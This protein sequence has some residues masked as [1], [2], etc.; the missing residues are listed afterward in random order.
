MEY[1]NEEQIKEAFVKYLEQYQYCDAAD[2]SF[3]AS[4]FPNP[5]TNG[6][7]EEEF[8]ESVSIGGEEYEKDAS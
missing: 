4:E 7:L 8:I 6:Y 5:Y 2:A 1:L 3:V